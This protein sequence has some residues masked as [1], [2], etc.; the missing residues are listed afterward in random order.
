L[1]GIG[2]AILISGSKDRWV[3]VFFVFGFL[4]VIVATFGA[5]DLVWRDPPRS[6]T[7]EPDAPARRT[8]LAVTV[9][10]QISLAVAAAGYVAI[11]VV[12]VWWIYQSRNGD[13]VGAWA[14]LP[15]AGLGIWRGSI[16]LRRLIRPRRDVREPRP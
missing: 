1:L 8:P 10:S 5:L 12:V 15:F 9:M 4:P 7:D 3:L 11:A 6:T 14:L 2:S 16:T 13:L